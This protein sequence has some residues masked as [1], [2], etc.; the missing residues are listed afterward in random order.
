MSVDALT[1]IARRVLDRSRQRWGDRGAV[2]M[3]GQDP[4]YRR[5]L[6]Q[7]ERFARVDRPVLITGETGVGKELFARALYLLSD[8]AEQPFV[9]VNCAQYRNEELLASELFGHRRGSFTGADSDRLGLFRRADGGTVF[10]DEVGE[11]PLGAQAMLLRVL[12]EGELSP[13][14]GSEIEHV[15][16]R[17]VAATNRS[18]DRMVVASRFRRDL[19]HRLSALRVGIPPVRERGADWRLLVDHFLEA[20]NRRHGTSRALT[21]AAARALSAYVWPGNVREIRSVIDVAYFLSEDGRLEVSTIEEYLDHGLVGQRPTEEDGLDETTV[22][23]ASMVR[24]GRSFWTV[25]REPFLQRDLNRR[26]VRSIIRRGLEETGGKYKP[27]LELFQ[28]DETEYGRFMD[29]LRHHRL[30]PGRRSV[31]RESRR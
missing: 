4:S 9:R 25:V 19:Y 31:R 1:G 22:R 16:V 18:L 24:E 14:G 8:R 5:A 12:G 7:L 15:D 20:L 27:L 2:R 30:K 13:L 10:L 28:M 23:F 26:Q 17:V 29:F 21:D 11:L 3:V 6:L